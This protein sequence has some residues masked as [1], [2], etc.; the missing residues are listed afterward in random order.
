MSGRRLN[1]Q[2]WDTKRQLRPHVLQE[3]ARCVTAGDDAATVAAAVGISVATARKVCKDVAR[4][5]KVPTAQD[6]RRQLDLSVSELTAAGLTDREIAERL[7]VPHHRVVLARRRVAGSKGSIPLTDAEYEHIDRMAIQGFNAGEIAAEIG[8]SRSSVQKRV[9]DRGLTAIHPIRT[10][11]DCGRPAGHAQKCRLQVSPD[12]VRERLLAG[13]TCAHIAR[14]VGRAPSISF[15]ALYCQPVI[16]QLT[17][18]GARCAC[19]QPFGHKFRC[20]AQG[21]RLR[22]TFTEQQLDQARLL[23]ADGATAQ[24]LAE[25]MHLNANSAG[26]LSRIVRKELAAAGVRCKCGAPIDHRHSCASRGP[27][28]FAFSPALLRATSQ[29]GRRRI[30]SLARKGWSRSAV[31]RRTGE[32]VWVVRLAF[33]E[34]GAAGLLPATCGRCGGPSGHGGTCSRVKCA[35]GLASGHRGECRPAKPPRPGRRQGL[36]AETIAEISR[37]YQL[38]HSTA[39]IAEALDLSVATINKHI[40]R[41]REKTGHTYKPCACG[42]PARHGGFCSARSPFAITRLEGAR[43]ETAIRAGEPIHRIAAQL[44]LSTEAVRRHSRDLRDRMF[45]A[46]HTCTCGRPIGHS[47]WCSTTWESFGFPSRARPLP[48]AKARS[49]TK[50]LLRGE[51]AENIAKAIGIGIRRVWEVRRSLS[52]EQLDQRARAVRRRSDRTAADDTGRWMAM[53]QK[54]VPKRIDRAIRDDIVAELHLAVLEGRLEPGQ[55]SAAARSFVSAGLKE[56]DDFNAP[57][58]LHQPVGGDP[59]NTVGDLIGDTTGAT[60]IDEI[61][62]G[63]APP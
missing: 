59:D 58:S 54:A 53:V 24:S 52:A 18:E 4:V 41:I 46:G 49:V 2:I 1:P 36:P 12:M 19:G 47:Q 56:W 61:E 44:S 15:R 14:E 31:A 40:N 39:S 45:A 30:A 7:A 9:R 16:D 5:L 23:L 27:G 42:R 21:A 48:A 25:V 6:L 55:I 26:V 50:A 43:I 29:Q 60:L 8:C 20:S 17:A 38:K 33:A 10:A 22:S 34:L 51:I 11:C 37:R 35:C 3:V 13:A 57:K 63:R 62:I 32:K 28:R